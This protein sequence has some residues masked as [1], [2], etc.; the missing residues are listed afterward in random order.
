[1]EKTTPMMK[2][3]FE[4]KEQYPDTLL[5]YRL[6]DFY[7]MFYEDAKIA[8]LECDLVLTSRFAGDNNKAP[9]CGVPHHAVVPYIQKLV[10]KGYKIAIVEQMED[11]K[12]TKGLVRRDVVRIITPGTVMDEISDDRTIVM[13]GSI[14]DIHYGYVLVACEMASGKT[15]ATITAYTLPDLFQTCLKYNIRE[16]VLDENINSKLL[17]K[18]REIPN[19]MISTCQDTQIQTHYEPL[20]QHIENPGVLT[21]YGRLINY[22]LTT[23]FKELSHLQVLEMENIEDYCEMDYTTMCNLELLI[24]LRPN[25]KNNTF[26]NYLDQCKSAMGSRMLRKWIEKP[27][28]HAD[29]IILKQNQVET[30]VKNYLLRDQLQ[31]HCRNIYDLERIIAKIAFKTAIPQDL[32]RLLKSLNQVLPIKT[33]LLDEIAFARWHDLDVLEEVLLQLETKLNADPPV[34]AKEGDIFKDGVDQ[35]LDYF[36][37]ITK[38]GNQWLLEFENQEKERTQI[39]NLKVGYNRVFGYYIEISKGNIPLVKEEFGYIRKQTLTNQERYVSE[40]LK[41]KEEELLN[42]KERANRLEGAM[43]SELIIDLQ[44]YLP[45]LQIIA[46]FL[47]MIDSLQSLATI[48]S[49]AGFVKP[50]FNQDRHVHIDEGVHPILMKNNKQGQVVSNS[51]HMNQEEHLYILTGPN[52]GGK[53]TY[54]RQIALLVIMAQMGCFVPAKKAELPIFDRIFTRMGASDDIMGGQ[55]TFMVE[56]NEAN[57][58]LQKATENSLILFD[59]IGRGTSTYD[60]M[61]IAQ[62]IIEYVCTVIKA[63]TIF[64]T[65]YHEL[66]SLAEQLKGV[67]N[68][69]VQVAEKDEDITFLYRVLKGKADKSY[70]IN[71]ARLAQLPPAVLD[72]SRILLKQLESKR[73][74]VQQSMDVVEVVTIPKELEEIKQ[75][76]QAVDIDTMTPVQSIFFLEQLKH[77]VKG[78]K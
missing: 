48:S 32:I 49:Q 71:V 68:M 19:I 72:R 37:N 50:N 39:K 6:G 34:N 54:M 22:L 9:M 18:L 27:L 13:I 51:L 73:R 36:R 31:Q 33:A 76:L 2:Q 38:N 52:M 65:H 43:F 44:Q 21:C 8:S 16:L 41:S 62:A 70:G 26:L 14:E 58:A 45:K 5:F 40:E 30:L 28:L 66:T 46:Q 78:K 1:M 10:N 3:Y 20:I 67:V 7:E 77:K 42:A 60:G 29:Q 61:A 12:L 75:L 57:V 53:S 15:I 63:K 24:P 74:F 47:A 56:M 64:S 4:V 69:Y 11:A 35:Q 17:K 25:G 23:Q 55:S 59:E